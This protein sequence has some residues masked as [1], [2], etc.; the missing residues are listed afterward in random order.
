MPPSV[1]TPHGLEQAVVELLA[2]TRRIGLHHI[3]HTARG[4][5]LRIE[6]LSV[7]EPIRIE[8]D[9]VLRFELQ[10][11]HD[12]LRG[13]DHSNRQAIGFKQSPAAIG[14]DDDWSA[15][16]SIDPTQQTGRVHER[17]KDG[18]VF[19]TLGAFENVPIDAGN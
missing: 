17:V 11:M 8:H 3:P 16:T 6:V 14:F 9:L 1:K 10:L 7:G 13:L 15:M 12:E 4:E 5:E 2:I 19:F 18:R